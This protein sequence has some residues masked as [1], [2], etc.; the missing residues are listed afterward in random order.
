MFD[1]PN[2]TCYL[3]NQDILKSRK[4][5]KSAHYQVYEDAFFKKAKDELLIIREQPTV[6]CGV[7]IAA[8]LL[9]MRGPRRFLFRQ[10]LGR[11][12]DQEAVFAKAVS[13]AK[14][15]EQAVGSVKLET[16]KLLERASFAEQEI[17]TGRTKLKDTGRQIQ[18]LVRHIN[19]IESDVTDFM[20][21]LREIP[22]GEALKLRKEV[23]SMMALARRQKA[24]LEKEITE[25]SELGI[26]V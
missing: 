15:L 6:A 17:Q 9:L 24:E 21:E 8:G 16:K 2:F 22:D 11:L 3:L 25:I 5:V 13:N 23:A 1:R 10:T 12:Q 19:R 26:R 14:E 20:D 7:A 4:L 18:S